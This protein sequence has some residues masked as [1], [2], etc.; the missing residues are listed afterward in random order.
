MVG[1]PSPNTRRSS[2]SCGQSVE[3]PPAHLLSPP[4][5]VMQNASC[6]D[7][8]TAAPKVPQ[9][10][11]L[12][13]MV[14]SETVYATTPCTPLDSNLDSQLVAQASVSDQV[15]T[16]HRPDS[17][18]T[19]A[20][21]PFITEIFGSG[22]RCPSPTV[23][24]IDHLPVTASSNSPSMCPTWKKSNELF[25]KIFSYQPNTTSTAPNHS[26]S[27]ETG[28]LFLGIK[29]GWSDFDA[30][31]QS[32][33]LSILKNVDEFLFANSPPL[34]RLAVAYKNYKLLKVCWPG[35]IVS[36]ETQEA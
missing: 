27:I 19:A 26:E 13:G 5:D 25:S 6:L 31:Q 21:A 4:Q 10:V 8:D 28:Y 18:S 34:Q 15:D 16:L 32:P 11:D 7:F 17:P 24:H 12:D 35:S 23:L 14:I 30:W 3:K 29:N 36:V 9:R 2:P 1:Q 22:Y 20:F 33:V